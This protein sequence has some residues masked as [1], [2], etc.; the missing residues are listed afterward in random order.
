LDFETV[1]YMLIPDYSTFMDTQQRIN[2]E[3][4]CRF[5]EGGI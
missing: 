2:L 3:L 4:F 5:Q 1:Y